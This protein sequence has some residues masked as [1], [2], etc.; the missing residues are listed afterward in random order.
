MGRNSWFLGILLLLSNVLV[1]AQDTLVVWRDTLHA[2]WM[3]RPQSYPMLRADTTGA[4]VFAGFRDT[5]RTSFDP[6]FV[7]SGAHDA[8]V[9]KYD[10]RG[11]IAWRHRMRN[12]G[13]LT[14]GHIKQLPSG[15]LAVIGHAQ[16]SCSFSALKSWPGG[17]FGLLVSSRG[18][19]EHVEVKVLKDHVFPDLTGSRQFYIA[20]SYRD[21]VWL[22]STHVYYD[23]SKYPNSLLA[24]YS[25]KSQLLWHKLL[26]T[27]PDFYR[28]GALY[29][30]GIALDEQDNVFVAG[31]FQGTPFLNKDHLRG[32]DAR[33]LFLASYSAK[34]NYRWSLQLSSSPRDFF[35]YKM[36]Y[37]HD[38]NRLIVEARSREGEKGYPDRHHRYAVLPDGTG[39]TQ[40]LFL[41]SPDDPKAFPE[42]LVTDVVPVADGSF[43]QMRLEHQ[44]L[45][46]E[47]FA[48][49]FAPPQESEASLEDNP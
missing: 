47:R 16:D 46:V 40:E 26:D 35:L 44:A 9:L 8:V 43:Y 10:P 7:S 21:S 1:E 30:H 17:A 29:A 12:K 27:I 22:D 38:Q 6:L 24:A 34:G 18:K 42:E 23:K 48:I 28:T 33:D 19:L 25:K 31:F 3:L 39:V 13:E 45:I 2:N 11:N 4:Y 49:S 37:R 14:V 41:L 20:Q 5:L 36:Y 15:K 32:F